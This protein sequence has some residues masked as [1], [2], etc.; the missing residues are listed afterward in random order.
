MSS[1]PRVTSSNPRVEDSMKAAQGFF[2]S[3]YFK[4]YE[5]PYF[6]TTEIHLAGEK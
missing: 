4:Y 5:K 6:M 2:Q 3:N 1:N